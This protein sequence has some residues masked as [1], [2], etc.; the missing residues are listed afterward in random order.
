MMRSGRPA[1]CFVAPDAYPVLSGGSESLHFGGAAVQQVLIARELRRRGFE[2]SFVTW[3]YGQPDGVEHGGIAVWRMCGRNDGFPAIRFISPRWTSLC[4]AL[5]RADA[6][7][8]YQRG[9]GSETGQVAMW[10]RS[11]RRAFLFAVA[12]DTNCQRGLDLGTRRERLLYRYGLR[13]ADGIIAQSRWQVQAIREVFSRDAVLIRSCGQGGFPPHWSRPNRSVPRLLWVGRFA[14]KK[15]FEFLLDLAESSKEWQFDV[16]G[17]SQQE[18]VYASHLSARAA[19]LSNVALH[20][21]LSHA[22]VGEVYDRAD[23]LICTSPQEGFPNTFLEAWA[24]GVPTVSTVDPDGIIA[25]NRLGGVA[26]TVPEMRQTIREL[27]D[28]PAGW[29]E[30]SR[31][32]QRYF[33]QN[34][35]IEAAGNAYEQLIRGLVSAGAEGAVAV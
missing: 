26:A 12:S 17:D 34:H 15:R 30:C 10:C 8:Y 2:V 32:V 11:R 22:A 29:E 24:R 25:M 19:R 28:S 9:A 27:V 23:L 7:L 6:D 1:I 35:S 14:P 31:R 3:D 21:R 4:R 33:A 20:G 13:R 18:G 5:R 16:I